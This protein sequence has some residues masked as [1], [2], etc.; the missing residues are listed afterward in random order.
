MRPSLRPRPRPRPTELRRSE[1]ALII[2]YRLQYLRSTLTLPPV[3]PSPSPPPARQSL[4]P[5]HSPHTTTTNIALFIYL[6]IVIFRAS[7]ILPRL[8]FSKILL[9]FYR[10][11]LSEREKIASERKNCLRAAAGWLVFFLLPCLLFE[12]SRCAGGLVALHHPSSLSTI[13]AQTSDS[14]TS[15]PSQLLLFFPII[16]PQ[17]TPSIPATHY[18]SPNKQRPPTKSINPSVSLSP[19]PQLGTVVSSLDTV[20]DAPFPDDL[21]CL[22]ATAHRISANRP[23]NVY[24]PEPPDGPVTFPYRSPSLSIEPRPANKPPNWTPLNEQPPKI[25]LVP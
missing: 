19:L 24:P 7:F 8:L 15:F 1:K 14:R 13:S 25:L 21:D 5:L 11:L 4:G 23:H 12:P 2:N 3:F 17:K 22:K 9:L 6:R 10:L 20:G 16:R 18:I